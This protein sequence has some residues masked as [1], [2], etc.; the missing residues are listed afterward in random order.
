MVEE[1]L[2]VGLASVA[3]PIINRAGTTVAAMNTSVAA[4]TQAPEDLTE[5]LPPLQAAAEVSNAL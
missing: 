1:E 3:V 4:T 5:L 2:E